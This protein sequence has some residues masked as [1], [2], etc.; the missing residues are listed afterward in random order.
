MK[1][2]SIHYIVIVNK[3]LMPMGYGTNMVDDGFGGQLNANLC[4]LN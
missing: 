3:Y 4:T 1:E 2:N